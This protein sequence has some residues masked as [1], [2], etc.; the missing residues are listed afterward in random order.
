MNSYN[1][2]GMTYIYSHKEDFS[3][4]VKEL[5]D[6]I[7][8]HSILAYI[9]VCSFI[10]TVKVVNEIFQVSWWM[11]I[12]C[13][14]IIFSAISHIIQKRITPYNQYNYK[15]PTKIVGYVMVILAL[16]LLYNLDKSGVVSLLN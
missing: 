16:V 5:M 10:V 1:K 12:T 6:S 11:A 13:Y 7:I 9:T 8:I 3:L 2:M 14:F 15:H 4:K